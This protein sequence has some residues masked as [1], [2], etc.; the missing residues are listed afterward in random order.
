MESAKA[1]EP[2]WRRALAAI[3]RAVNSRAL[4]STVAAAALLAGC[5]NPGQSYASRHPELSVAHRQILSRGSIPSGDAVAGMTREQVKLAMGGDPTTFDRIDGE[6]AWV[7]AHKKMVGNSMFD[8][9]ERAGTLRMENDHSFSQTQE[10]GPRMDV[11][12][13]TTVFFK[14]DGATHAITDEAAA[15]RN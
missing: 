5:A 10:L 4:F 1:S 7:Y 2:L 13:K 14:G 12:V 9:T 8:D 15:Q 3:G 6:D 11:E